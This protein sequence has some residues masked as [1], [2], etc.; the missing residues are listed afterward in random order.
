MNKKLYKSNDRILA[1]VL[2][3]IGDYFNIDHN[4]VRLIFVALF[5]VSFGVPMTLFYII[6]AIIM[7]TRPSYYDGNND[8][9]IQEGEFHE[10]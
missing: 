4:V 1:G 8:S 5:L 9:N 6:A 2:G 7:P 3:G 10:D